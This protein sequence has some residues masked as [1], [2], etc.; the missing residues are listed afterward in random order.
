MLI[1]GMLILFFLTYYLIDE[2]VEIHTHDP[3]FL[4]ICFSLSN[5]VVSFQFIAIILLLLLLNDFLVLKFKL[6]KTILFVD[7]NFFVL[8]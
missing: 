8:L 2:R 5:I 6:I 7:V 1:R 3:Y 4:S